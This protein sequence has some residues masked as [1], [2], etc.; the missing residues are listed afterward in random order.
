[1]LDEMRYISFN[2]ELHPA[3]HDWCSERKCNTSSFDLQ[4]RIQYDVFA[5][6]EE[7]KTLSTTK[8]SLPSRAKNARIVSTA[9]VF[10]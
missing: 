7:L 9:E 2:G 8:E 5:V 4:N 3:F 1:M 6:K 10:L